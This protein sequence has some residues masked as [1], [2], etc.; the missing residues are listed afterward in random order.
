MNFLEAKKIVAAPLTGSEFPVLFA[1]SCNGDPLDLF[2]RAHAARRGVV[3]RPRLL[4]FGT[5]GQTLAAP[6]PE[7]G[8][9]ELF[10]LLPWDFV[11]ALDWRSGLGVLDDIKVARIAAAEVA[12]RLSRRR[13]GRF[14]YLPAPLPPVTHSRADLFS[15]EGEIAALA[16][17]LGAVM[18]SEEDFAL[19]PYLSSGCPV[20]GTRQSAV[21]ERLVDLLLGPTTG[22][23]K[24]VVTDLDNTLWSGIV[25]EDG[26]DAVHANP[27]GIGFRHFLY[28]TMLG[29][30]RASGILLAAVSRNDLDLAKAPLGQG[31]MPLGL[32]DFVAVCATYGAK[33]HHIA[34][35]A[36]QLNLGLDSFVFID[37]NPVELAEVAVAL[38]QVNCLHFPDR[39]E[40]LSGLLSRLAFLGD[41]HSLTAEDGERTEMYRRRLA[42]LPP[43]ADGE[44]VESFLRG[45]GM[46]LTLRD[47][48]QEGWQRALQLINKTNQFNLNGIRLDEEELRGVL[49]AGGHLFTAQLDDRSG[50]HGEI[51][52]CLLDGDG[53]IRSLVM[54]CRVFERRV[55][56][57]FLIWLG[58][59]LSAKTLYLEYRATERNEPVRRLLLDPA[60]ASCESF[61]QLDVGAFSAT[62]A[63]V[64]ALFDIVEGEG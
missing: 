2:L 48:S 36:Q 62:H 27:E 16:A 61:W 35:L 6:Q 60:F 28:Q 15:L 54:S 29:R 9:S 46:V 12:R 31:R 49:A 5:L 3:L 20:P 22:S 18:L 4:P 57:A 45:L 14:A 51:L 7:N 44:G 40:D 13:S 52:A 50:T 39:I 56:H 47:R 17:G 19:S 10:L 25:G 38:P 58:R 8:D 43:A 59:E 33:S 55:E 42:T 1:M 11:P 63:D 21:A 26:P 32:D 23:V 24:I 64:L 34:E 53:T 30:L 37:D 41:R